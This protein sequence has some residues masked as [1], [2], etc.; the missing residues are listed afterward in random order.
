MVRHARMLNIN[1]NKSAI[2]LATKSANTPKLQQV[3]ET[4]QDIHSTIS[5]IL[6]FITTVT[7]L[8]GSYQVKLNGSYNGSVYKKLRKKYIFSHDNNILWEGLG[9]VACEICRHFAMLPLI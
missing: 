6:A 9:L 7:M 2:R 5:D 4:I 1:P 3:F 8:L